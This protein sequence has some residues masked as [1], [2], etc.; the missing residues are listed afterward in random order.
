M[1][2]INRLGDGLSQIFGSYKDVAVNGFV[3]EKKEGVRKFTKYNYK[4][5]VNK[6]LYKSSNEK[7]YCTNTASKLNDKIKNE[8][9]DLLK[10]DV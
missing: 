6:V 5:I 1:I 3:S 8:I 7:N 4:F 2:K 10:K 9:N